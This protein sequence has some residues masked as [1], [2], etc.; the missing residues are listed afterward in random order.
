MYTVGL[1]QTIKSKFHYKSN[2]VI[3]SIVDGM[4]ALIK[5]E[6]DRCILAD[7]LIIDSHKPFGYF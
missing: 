2:F 5:T 3:A 4:L 6:I 7:W 1:S